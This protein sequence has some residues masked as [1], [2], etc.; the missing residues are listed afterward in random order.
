[1]RLW[2]DILSSLRHFESL[3]CCCY[4][5]H[6]DNGSDCGFGFNNFMKLKDLYWAKS[7]FQALYNDEIMV[8]ALIRIDLSRLNPTVYKLFVRSVYLTGTGF[9]LVTTILPA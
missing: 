5:V 9:L 7:C 2:V 8:S 6:A 3:I 4:D 1:M